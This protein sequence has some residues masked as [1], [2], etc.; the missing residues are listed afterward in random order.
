[1]VMRYTS[2]TIEY[3]KRTSYLSN[4]PLHMKKDTISIEKKTL[5]P[6]LNLD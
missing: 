5:K 4:A 3:D 1:M 2:N 6:P